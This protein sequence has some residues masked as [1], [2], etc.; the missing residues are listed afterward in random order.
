MV[1]H[2]V[3]ELMFKGYDDEL[4]QLFSKLNMTHVIP[5]D[6]FGWFYTV[7]TNETENTNLKNEEELA[8]VEESSN[9]LF[10]EE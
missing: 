9:T 2:T 4:L 10:S 5:F 3:E 1:S 7:S 8:N 6:K